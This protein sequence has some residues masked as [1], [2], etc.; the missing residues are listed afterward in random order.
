MTILIIVLIL[1]FALM[2]SGLPIYISLGL[3]SLVYFL[4]EGIASVAAAHTMIGGLDS[5]TLIA[6]PFFIFAGHLMNATGFTDRIFTFARAVVGRAPGGLGHVNIGA[7]VVF[8]L[9]LIHI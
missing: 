6:I 9:S 1:L 7:S 3:S 8:A 5:F 4:S 2:A